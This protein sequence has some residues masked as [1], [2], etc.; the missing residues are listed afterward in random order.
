[1]WARPS[2]ELREHAPRERGRRYYS[3]VFG[4]PMHKFFEGEL[5]L[6]VADAGTHALATTHASSV[7]DLRKTPSHFEKPW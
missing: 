1:M 5:P 4:Q 3:E 7:P 6:R 2:D